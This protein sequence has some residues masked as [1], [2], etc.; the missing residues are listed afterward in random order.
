MVILLDMDGT[1]IDSVGMTDR[2]FQILEDVFFLKKG[3]LLEQ[4]HRYRGMYPSEFSAEGFIT[5]LHDH[6][7]EITDFDKFD[8]Q[9]SLAFGQ[10]AQEMI[11]NDVSN[12]LEEL[13]NNRA[14]ATALYS[15]GERAWQFLK[16]SNAFGEYA[17]GESPLFAEDMQFVF[18]NKTSPEAVELVAEKLRA[19]GIT[20]A[21]VVDDRLE[22]LQRLQTVWPKDIGLTCIHI[23]RATQQAYGV[24]PGEASLEV[25]GVHVISSLSQVSET[26]AHDSPKN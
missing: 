6:L 5:Y 17:S 12:L 22:T 2:A 18:A 25:P 13:S 9:F 24:H 7:I 8:F 14:V 11:Y 15:Q 20:H 4:Y 3:K 1:L 23:K 10:S 26:V 21:A 16:F 19:K